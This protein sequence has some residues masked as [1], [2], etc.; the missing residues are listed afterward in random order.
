[1]AQLSDVT[2]LELARTEAIKL[3]E[4]D[5]GLGKHEHHLLSKELL[6]VWQQGAA[7]WS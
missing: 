5:P 6:R 1:M 2:L 4:E 7:E 3:F